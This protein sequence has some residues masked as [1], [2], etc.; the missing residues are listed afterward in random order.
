VRDYSI[1]SAQSRRENIPHELQS[2]L[3]TTD[4]T[5]IFTTR[6]REVLETAFR[7]GYFEIPRE[8][9]L[10]AVAETLDIDKSSASTTLR[11]AEGRLLK[12]VLTGTDG[13]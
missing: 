3:T 10:A 9:S 2:L 12:Q 6:Q 4:S 8:S 13:I 7:M 5:D 11:R 1:A